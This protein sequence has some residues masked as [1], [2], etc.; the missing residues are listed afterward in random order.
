MSSTAAGWR[1]ASRRRC[2]LPATCAPSSSSASRSSWCAARMACCAPFTTSAPTTAVSRCAPSSGRRRRSRSTTTA[3]ATTSAVDLSPRRTGTAR[4]TGNPS[5]S[6]RAR[7]PRRDPLR[8]AARSALR[9]PGRS[10]GAARRS[11][12][13]PLR[14]ARRVRPGRRGARRGGRHVR[15]HRAHGREQLE[16]LAGERRDQRPARELHPRGVPP[17]ARHP[18]GARGEKT[19]FTV[20]E[21]P[22]LAFGFRMD[23]VPNTYAAEVTLRT[24]GG[25]ARA[26]LRRAGS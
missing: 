4:R 1:S 11:P 24:S 20:C 2:P 5:C 12:R 14:V 25:R 26:H 3:G 16:D 19:F 9:G 8:D 21:G 10:C 15:A 6:R 23:D 18:A 13:A 17:I 22:L 7:R